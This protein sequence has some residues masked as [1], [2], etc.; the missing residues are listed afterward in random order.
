MTQ[1]TKKTFVIACAVLARDIQRVAEQMSMSV[2]TK[3]L[4]AGLH[5]RPNLLRKKLQ[6]AIDEV[7]ASNRWERIVIGY[8]VCGRGTVGIQAREIPLTIPKVHDCIALFLGGD[9]AYQREFKK[10]PGTY[11]LSAGWY[12]KKTEPISQQQKIAA[13]GEKKLHYGE[14]V[15]KYG[16]D[17]AKETFLFLN[18]WKKNYQRA[19]FIE[20]EAKDSPACESFAR[21]MALQYGWKY[22]KLKGNSVL[23]KNL[24]TADTTTNEILLVPPHHILEFNAIEST[25]SANPVWVEDL[26]RTDNIT[27]ELL[28]ENN[29]REKTADRMKMGLGIDAGGTYTDAVIYDFR[30]HKVLFKSKALTTKW[31][32]TKGIETALKKLDQLKLKQVEMVSLSTTLATN[33]IV[34]GEGQRVGM[35][36]MPPYGRLDKKEIPCEPKAIIQGQLQ[37][38]GKE[39]VPVE[40]SEVRRIAR[41]MVQEHRIKAIAVS[42]FAGAINPEHELLVKQIVQDETGLTVT[43]GHE[44][45][46]ILN[47]KTRAYTAMLNARI[48]PKLKRLI[49]NLEKAIQAMGIFAPIVVVKGDGTLMRSQMA[50]ERPVETILSGPAASV[51]GARHLTGFKD[52]IVVDMGGTTTDTAVLTDSC[53]RVCEAGSNVGGHHTHVKALD[54]R[55][56]GFGGDSM[57][58]WKKQKFSIGPKRVGSIAWLGAVSTGTDK[59]IRFIDSHLDQ[60]AASTRDMQ[61]LAL[62]GTTNRLDLTSR[63]K[64]ILNFLRSRPRAMGELVERTGV[65]F[66]SGLPIQRLEE[67]GIIQRCSLTITDLLHVQEFMSRW[68]RDSAERYCRLFSRLTNMT[69]QE[70]TEKIFDM[71]V[72]RLALEILKH[73]LDSETDPEGIETCP[74]CRTMIKNM[75]SG[76]DAQYHVRIDL[77]RPLIGVGAPIHIFLPQISKV[78]GVE[79]ILPEHAD[80]ANAI[81]AIT[82][83]VVVKQH[84]RIIPNQEGGFLIDGLAGTR[85]FERFKA[86]D[87]FAREALTGIV[88]RQAWSAGTSTRELE[89]RTEDDIASTADGKKIFM[90]RS[91]HAILTGRPDLAVLAEGNESN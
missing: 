47:F 67:Y 55:T 57:I 13:F 71:G 26:S 12:D 62:T 5:D 17:A 10:Y 32:F 89:L 14:L 37:I 6:A 87:T 51:A 79:T 72:E 28:K 52:A 69:I 49:R 24:L 20:T 63:E 45:S 56:T 35:I 39:I 43:C 81:G 65:L 8:G 40:A 88:R 60:Y 80:V 85:H 41:K 19:A 58:V 53:V 23:L 44:L 4:E 76:G 66:S 29:A 75:L 30:R 21:E 84:L 74:V 22:E 1:K 2:G 25:L 34:E 42:G 50:M 90:G 9:A 73:Q 77:K 86:A 18:T 38:N 11:Y 61:I 27:V 7:S 16:E 54:I 70:L 83:N 36:L 48:I 31:D 46:H 3:F 68:D 78:L 33:A 15:K 59:A 64:A 82:S 91:I